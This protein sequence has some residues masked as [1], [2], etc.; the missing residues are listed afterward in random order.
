M[1]T[2][3]AIAILL[4]GLVN[5]LRMSGLFVLGNYYDLLSWWKTLHTKK[6]RS[7]PTIDIVIAAYNEEVSIYRCLESVFASSYPKI[8]VIVA[9]DGSTDG[10]LEQV[11]AY[12]RAHPKRKITVVTQPNGGKARALNHAIKKAAR[13]KYIMTLDA[14][15]ILHSEALRR[16]LTYFDDKKISAVA[17]NVR[18]LPEPTLLSIVQQVEYLMG[19]RLKKAYTVLNNEYILGGIGSI[20]RRKDLKEVNYYDTNTITEDIDLTLK[21]IR[22]GNQDRSIAY[23]SDAICYTEGVLSLSALFRQ[24]FRWKYG[25]MQSLWKNKQLFFNSD[26]KY[27]KLLTYL[28]LPFVIYS[29]VTF[30]GDPLFFGYIL[31]LCASYLDTTSFQ[32]MCLFAAFYMAM[33]VM[34]D[35]YLSRK[36]KV[37]L[38]FCSP[39]AFL[40]FGIVSVVEYAALLK[41]LRQLKGIVFAH[42]QDNCGWEHVERQL[43]ASARA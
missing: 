9:N 8:H 31:L 22:R 26:K 1:T 29:E 28:Q 5:V 23:A 27:S 30:L 34:V 38:L 3:F 2:P 35:E 4:F 16:M 7:Y 33:V 6:R 15:S 36:H 20:F 19:Y 37:L 43:P 25:R 24:R 42:E 13:S 14:D 21:L 10:T 32:G 12:K 17:A 11:T 41:C 18:I 39:L 40:L